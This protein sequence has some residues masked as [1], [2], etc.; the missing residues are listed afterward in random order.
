MFCVSHVGCGCVLMCKQV[1]VPNVP[2]GVHEAGKSVEKADAI[3]SQ[4]RDPRFAEMFAGISAC[5]F[6]DGAPAWR[7]WGAGAAARPSGDT[8]RRERPPR[9]GFSVCKSTQCRSPSGASPPARLFP[10][11]LNHVLSASEGW[12]RMVRGCPEFAWS[13]SSGGLPTSA[14]SPENM[15]HSRSG[16]PT[17]PVCSCPFQ[18]VY[19]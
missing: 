3:F 18:P 16:C 4:D 15:A 19:H 5:K 1:P 2:A 11:A 8:P 13:R 7:V 17:K 12:E 9:A 14:L 6:P 10:G